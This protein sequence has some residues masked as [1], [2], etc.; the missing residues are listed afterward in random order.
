MKETPTTQMLRKNIGEEIEAGAGEPA[1]A[2]SIV[3]DPTKTKISE[4]TAYCKAAGTTP[5]N[6]RKMKPAEKREA[7][8]ALYCSQEVEDDLIRNVVHYVENLQ[9]DKFVQEVE[10]RIENVGQNYFELGGILARVAVEAIFGKHE[11]FKDWLE[12]ET[13]VGF[14]KARYLIKNYD[15][16]VELDIPFTK[17]QGLGW[18]K[19][20]AMLSVITLENVDEWVARAKELT[21]IQLQEEVKAHRQQPE[22]GSSPE[23]TSSGA[24]QKK[25]NLFADQV[26]MV[27]AALEQMKK[28][29]PTEHENVALE[30]ICSAYVAGGTVVRRDPLDLPDTP[31]CLA[32]L[33]TILERMKG[34][35]TDDY[36]V[37]EALP[38]VFDEVFPNA[39][40][41]IT[42]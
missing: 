10:A 3:P 14:R 31:A 4:L 20:V 35:T 32:A 30:A 24:K 1:T 29:L 25:F 7:F 13:T 23:T 39:D 40:I 8:A 41:R 9:S 16:L 15:T 38:K 28:D 17:F 5:E 42:G 37:L 18:T 2:P 34:L 27:E 21:L 22:N 11:N 12:A 33:G 19:V 26:E 36:D 6:W